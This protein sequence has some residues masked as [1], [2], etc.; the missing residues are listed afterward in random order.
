MKTFLLSASFLL[1]CA[2]CSAQIPN[3]G[4]ELWDFQPVPLQWTTNSH[5]LTLPPYDPYIV[6]Q[7]TERYAGNYAANF[8]ANGVL[9]PY[10]TATFPVNIHPNNLSLY[11]KLSFP[12][13]VNNNGFPQ[14]DTASILVELL[15]GTAVVDSGYWESITTSF[16]YSQLVIPISQNATAFDSC[17]I[18]IQGGRVFGGCG[19]IAAS[20]EFKVDQLELKYSAHTGCIDS[21]QICL[22]CHCITVYNPVCGCD[23]ITYTNSC[24]ASIAGVT[25]WSQG[26]CDTTSTIDSCQLKGVVVQGVECLL[27]HDFQSGN[28]LMP[29]SMPAGAVWQLGDTVFY[30]YTTT[31]CIS[32]C[33]QGVNAD[34]TCFTRL[35]HPDTLPAGGDCMAHFTYTR[36]R[37]TVTFSNQ[38]TAANISS[39]SWSFGDG[40]TSAQQNPVHR[41]VQDSAFRVCLTVTGTDSAGHNCTS[42]FCDTISISHNCIDSSL[43]C[44]FPLCC[45]FVPQLPVCGCDSVTYPN[46]CQATSLYGVSSYYIG[47]CVTTGITAVSSPADIHISPNPAKDLIRVMY[48]T[49][50]AGSS[51]MVITNIL[52]QCVKY[53]PRA[54]ETTGRHSADINIA[55]LQK[56]IYLLEIKTETDRKLKKFVAE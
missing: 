53:L 12:P 33:Q 27:I 55:D 30:D 35:S 36:V 51:E 11:Y 47:H 31:S 26:A 32:I 44:L 10:A 29:C 50:H 43:L 17:R 38:S 46:P 4:F 22:S 5:P 25:S 13:C 56:G 45:D 54:F 18:T 23:G 39:Y 40:D 6:K 41:F 42:T 19:I 20:T 37:D 48:E 7:D 9:K 52:G 49:S 3:A 24:F 21:S 16:N 28:E 2:L 1:V 34:F 14:K 8:H 15:N